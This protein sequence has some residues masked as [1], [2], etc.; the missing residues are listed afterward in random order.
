M[1]TKSRADYP[2]LLEELVEFVADAL[3]QSGLARDPAAEAAFAIVERVREN[4]GGVNVYIPKGSGYNLAQR[5]EEIRIHPSRYI[6]W[7]I[8]TSA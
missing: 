1:T 6:P 5:N 7:N 2:D 4:F 3:V 8:A